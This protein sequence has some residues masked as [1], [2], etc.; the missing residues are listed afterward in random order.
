MVGRR[1]AVKVTQL[2]DDMNILQELWLAG[3]L[4]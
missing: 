3:G 4:Q 1:A 2:A